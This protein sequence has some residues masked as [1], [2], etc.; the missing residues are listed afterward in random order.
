MDN[1]RP[2]TTSLASSG[3]ILYLLKSRSR[4][5]Q[6]CTTGL[7]IMGVLG[8]CSGDNGTEFKGALLD[9]CSQIGVK[10]VH[11]APYKPSTRGSVQ[12][13]NRTFKPWLQELQTERGVR[14]WAYY[15]PEISLA[16][17]TS[18]P[19]GL[20]KGLRSC[21]FTQTAALGQRNGSSLR[22][23][24]RGQKCSCSNN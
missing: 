5:R 4:L 12:S 18:R 23:S 17:N 16:I 10:V 3:C 21:P 20:K 22:P 13:A 24:N 9:L 1:F 11:G 14:N 19:Y 7:C 2:K 8:S 15:L 6:S